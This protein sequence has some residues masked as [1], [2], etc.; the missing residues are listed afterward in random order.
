M[1]LRRLVVSSVVQLIVMI[2]V[3]FV[4]AGT[5]RWWQA[6]L[7]VAL[8]VVGSIATV[9]ALYPQHK[10]ILEERLRPPIQKN[11]P[12]ADKVLVSAL[13]VTIFAA[14]LFIPIDVFRLHHVLGRPSL[15]VSAIGL[16][17]AAV[18]WWLIYRTLVAN[19][20]AAPAVKHERQQRVVDTG[21]Y[22]IVRHPMYSGA[23]LFMVGMPLWLGSLAATLAMVVPI[24][25]MAVRAVFEERFLRRELPGYASYMQRVRWRLVPGVW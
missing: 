14:L 8:I 16:V 1:L 19:A 24:C 20:F 25:V 17:L 4:P 23:I 11:Q 6:W 3:L 18:G 2:V 15:A 13:L 12:L 9:A 5:W 21:P 10:D 22:A 7:L